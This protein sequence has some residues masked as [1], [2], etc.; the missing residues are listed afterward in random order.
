[1]KHV[2]FHASAEVAS[3]LANAEAWRSDSRTIEPIHLFLAL[4]RIID[5]V[6]EQE[7][8]RMGLDAATIAETAA[9]AEPGREL[10]GLADDELA[11]L[12]RSLR[13]SR[14]DAGRRLPR[15]LRWSDAATEVFERAAIFSLES[16]ATVKLPHLVR[17][18]LLDPPADV[19]RFLPEAG[20]KPALLWE[21]R[22]DEFVETFQP[23][24][25]AL[26]LTDMEG[27][28]AIK[29]RYG[30][31]DSARI[32]RSHDTLFRDAL[33]EFHEAREVKTIGDSF[34]L[35]FS[36]A[37]Q[38][39]RYCLVTQARLRAH[40]ELSQL[41][42]PGGSER[43]K[44]QPLRVR[45]GIFAGPIL[46]RVSGGSGLSD[47]V[48]GITIDTTARIASLAAGG[49][50]LTDRGVCKASR[51]AL[52]AEP[53]DG[54]GAIE[55][56]DHGS[57]SLKGL[58]AP[59]E[60]FEV[61]ETSEASFQKPAATEKAKPADVIIQGTRVRQ[62]NET[63]PKDDLGPLARD[64]SALARAGRLAPVVGRRAEMKALARYLQRTSKPNVLVI[65]EAGVGKT[66]IVEGLAQRL[67][68]DA[69]PEFLRNTR[70]VQVQVADLVAGTRYR[71]DL[72]ERLRDLLVR[73]TADPS[74]VLFLDEVH[75][76]MKAG[77]SRGPMDVANILKPAL[78]SDEM[79]CIGATTTDEFE[80]YIQ[81]DRAFLRRF[82]LLRVDEP[83][84]DET[85][86]MCRE[87][88]RRIEDVQEVVFD[89]EAVRAAVTLSA[90]RI[91]DRRLPDK[92]IDLLENAAVYIK[93]SSLSFRPAVPTKQQRPL[94]GIEGGKQR[95]RIGRAEIEAVLEEQQP[96]AAGDPGRDIGFAPQPL[97][98]ESP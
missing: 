80:R 12:R 46:H 21:T 35:A 27:S 94:G 71:G 90:S 41:R 45:M 57:Y 67:A 49:Q 17:A 25:I 69:A 76:V 22:I 65:G 18:F 20:R 93:V 73:V 30:D 70:I 43:G 34:L 74:L 81:D 82:Q 33:K 86:E 28:M 98:G 59:V 84:T 63:F 50:I 2:P 40:K 15:R 8:E 61:G 14:S 9:M 3:A 4:L 10:L 79:R 77:A 11:R 1:M 26:V 31:R 47:P 56:R 5:G 7:A 75:L 24:Q 92:A 29:R 16:D 97:K 52:A 91:R 6:F 88:V 39:V 95:P 85:L 78:A 51:E 44:L 42:P 64:L 72:E 48:F 36:T 55:W 66:A 37:E 19:V 62:L 58:D 83:S 89:D 53:Q 23:V 38:A 13:K 60:I 87:W 96:R 68:E 54:L 32:F